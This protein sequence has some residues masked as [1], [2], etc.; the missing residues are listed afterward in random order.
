MFVCG[1]WFNVYV[2]CVAPSTS[3]LFNSNSFD[4]FCMSK[5]VRIH[6]KVLRISPIHCYPRLNQNVHATHRHCISCCQYKLHNLRRKKEKKTK[7]SK[8]ATKSKRNSA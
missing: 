8:K 6:F 4:G 2:V 5:C 3:S 7:K 1:H